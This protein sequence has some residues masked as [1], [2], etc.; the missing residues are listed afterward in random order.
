MDF[1]P[2]N[3]LY[4][5]P[6]VTIDLGVPVPPI[7]ARLTRGSSLGSDAGIPSKEEEDYPMHASCRAILVSLLLLLI[8]YPSWSDEIQVPISKQ[9]GVWVADVTLNERVTLPF[10]IDSGAAEVQVT[11]DV[12]MILLRSGTISEADFLPGGEYR[13]ADGSTTRSAR[14]KIRTMKIGEAVA[15]N[16][17]SFR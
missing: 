9:G 16:V 6:R 2:E 15:R 1:D 4:F 14:F 12:V 11:P 10:V 3:P 17:V 13:L 5:H 7:I 8:S